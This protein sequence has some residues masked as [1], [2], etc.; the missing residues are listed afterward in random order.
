MPDISLC[1]N[2]TCPLRPTCYRAQAKPNPYRQAYTSYT[3][4]ED[5]TCDDYVEV[6]CDDLLE[7]PEEEEK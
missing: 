7:I 1:R 4:N 6:S 3:P 5:G 2:K